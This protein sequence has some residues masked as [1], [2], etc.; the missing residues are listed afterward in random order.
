MVSGFKPELESAF[1]LEMRG[2]A[3]FKFH[4]ICI[5]ENKSNSNSNK[6]GRTKRSK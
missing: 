5:E 4:T 3:Q 1:E 6:Q 2:T